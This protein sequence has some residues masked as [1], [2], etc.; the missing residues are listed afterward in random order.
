MF[1]CVCLFLLYSHFFITF[2]SSHFS[3][4][5]LY[6]IYAFIQLLQLHSELKSEDENTTNIEIPPMS[7][8]DYPNVANRGVLWSYRRQAKIKFKEMRENI[9][10]F[11]KLRINMLMLVVDVASEY[12]MINDQNN[13]NNNLKNNRNKIDENDNNYENG[14]NDNGNNIES[15]FEQFPSS[16]DKVIKIENN[17]KENYAF[18]S[19]IKAIDE[20]C[21]NYCIELIPF[22]IITSPNQ[23]LSFTTLKTFSHTMLYGIFKFDKKSL[24]HDMKMKGMN[25]HECEKAINDCFSAA[26]AT[27][28]SVGFTSLTFGCP[29]WVSRIV[30]SLVGN[31]MLLV[32]FCFNPLFF[33]VIAFIT[34]LLFIIITNALLTIMYCCALYYCVL[35]HTFL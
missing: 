3:A 8:I 14:T 31:V 1:S 35:L 11:S 7:M 16:V 9:E 30:N 5:W 12:E 20:I 18:Y 29:K 2:P 26:V 25:I 27:I 33:V 28:L 24:Y 4:G 17:K 23:R 19:H 6:G 10:I 15:K 32:F 13:S 22:V 21:K 34:L